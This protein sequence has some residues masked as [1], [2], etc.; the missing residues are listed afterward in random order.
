MGN[1]S[2][3]FGDTDIDDRN[4]L[5]DTDDLAW[6]VS[7]EINNVSD[8]E[9]ESEDS[10]VILK[11][12]ERL[13]TGKVE[14]V[15]VISCSS[16]GH[17]VGRP[18]VWEVH[19][20]RMIED[21]T[22]YCEVTSPTTRIS[23]GTGVGVKIDNLGWI[24][25]RIIKM[26]AHQVEVYLCDYGYNV[27][28]PSESVSLHLLLPRHVILP[29]LAQAFHVCGVI[30]A[31]GGGWTRTANIMTAELLERG[32]IEVKVMG[33]PVFDTNLP[34][35]PSYPADIYVIEQVTM[36]PMDPITTTRINLTN[37]L[38]KAGLALPSRV[39]H[40]PFVC[41]HLEKNESR[42]D[43]RK[44]GEISREGEIN[45]HDNSEDR[46]QIIVIKDIKVKNKKLMPINEE[47]NL[48]DVEVVEGRE[49]RGEHRSKNVS[50]LFEINGE[51][52]STDKKSDLSMDW[53]GSDKECERVNTFVSF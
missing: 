20:Y 21:L 26:Y 31:G 35:L 40:I 47:E 19:Y 30:A 12:G 5:F 37:T 34:F 3:A 22:G 25:A 42:G 41:E 32:Q 36:G 4:G 27:T 50:T 11:Q 39:L 16:P 14:Q 38:R 10:P 46:D 9:S 33:P 8:V 51:Q 45:I 49:L 6:R 17:V 23:V 18:V 15:K 29:H 53:R 7:S 2:R 48:A 52:G 44:I 13:K 28:L 43:D 1:I 24:R